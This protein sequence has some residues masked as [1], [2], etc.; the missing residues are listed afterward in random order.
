MAKSHD[1]HM[2]KMEHH[3]E[4]MMHHKKEASLAKKHESGKMT[5]KVKKKEK[6]KKDGY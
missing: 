6:S 3:K 4:K 1:H 2:E 5:V